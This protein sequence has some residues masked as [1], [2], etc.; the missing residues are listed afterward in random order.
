M[1]Q[2]APGDAENR[3]V[4]SHPPA[5]TAGA[6]PSVTALVCAYNY[7]RYVAEAIESA[8]AQDYPAELI[9]VLVIDDGSTD[10]T[11]EILRSYGDR[12]RVVRQPNGGLLAATARG[13][14]EARGDLIAILD[15]DDVWKP[16]KVRRQVELMVA[17][18][19]VGFVFS[20]LEVIDPD[21]RTLATSFWK[22]QGLRPS[23]G[24]VLAR[25]LCQNYATAPSV[26]FRRAFA[27]HVLPIDPAAFFQDWWLAV[28]IAEVAEIDFIPEPLTLYRS[29]AD[30]MSKKLLR[31]LRVD[32][33][34]RRWMLR[35]LDLRTVTPEQMR[36]AWAALEEKVRFTAS[37]AGRPL[38]AELSV[39]DSDRA[40]LGRRM[41]AGAAAAA[42]GEI[43]AAA[44]EYLAARASDPFDAAAREAFD[45]ITDPAAG[46][47]A[48]AWPLLRGGPPAGADT[49]DAARARTALAAG[50][51]HRAAHWIG[52]AVAAGAPLEAELGELEFERG[53]WAAAAGAWT[54]A[55]ERAPLTPRAQARLEEAKRRDRAAGQQIGGA[56]RARGRVLLCVEEFHPLPGELAA[57]AEEL[58][59]ELQRLG[60]SVEVA[61][62]AR[63]ERRERSRGGMRVHEIDR[64]PVPAVRAV[65]DA[66]GF[67]AVLACSSPDGWP[68]PAALNL[69]RSGPRVVVLQLPGGDA[70]LRRSFTHVATYRALL[71]RA[72]AVAHVSAA[73]SDAR[74]LVDLG[75]DAVH[76]P[77]GCAEPV[78][79][80]APPSVAQPA[81]GTPL[82]LAVGDYTRD[83]RYGELLRALAHES[84]DWRLAIAGGP[85][86]EHGDVREE[87]RRLAGVD[88]RVV[89]VPGATADEVDALM[90]RAT[91]LLVPGAEPLARLLVRAMSHGLPWIATPDCPGAAD[92]AGGVAVAREEIGAA[93]GW[94]LAEEDARDRLAVAGREQWARAHRSRDVAARCD[95]LL[96]GARDLAAV[97]VA[98]AE[99]DAVRGELFDALARPRAAASF[100]PLAVEAHA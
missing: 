3:V 69:P 6:L 20:D 43:H 56:P 50:D 9:E 61:T 98:C 73:G 29:H 27:D 21:G 28:K 22:D 93:L 2:V 55:A 4:P 71:G 74:L 97:P 54:A 83:R 65:V 8:F 7:E 78:D 89:T 88:R 16:E 100:Q 23:R 95:A 80:A 63:P 25:F 18:P 13:I 77:V 87:I 17:R 49:P 39:E 64:G 38:A 70:A 19:E 35:R 41:A 67:D 42:R 24:R 44:R 90:A 26:M 5:A 72:D 75:V 96:R 47:G 1:P 45:A 60:W 52:R 82:L 12:I 34:F 51:V 94:L 92:H 15:A 57:A 76:L 58:G 14:E 59:C 91:V 40:E 46:P 53:R 68:L 33:R 99:T 66:G 81:A 48:P 37:H 10:G 30:N 31:N 79:G 86:P 85:L 36:V 32:N 62:R 84:G 11:P